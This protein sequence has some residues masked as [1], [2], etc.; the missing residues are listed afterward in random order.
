MSLYL[1]MDPFFF[2]M[3]QRQKHC[4][5]LIIDVWHAAAEAHETTDFRFE[6][7]WR[8]CFEANSSDSLRVMKCEDAKRHKCY[9]HR[10]A[11]CILQTVSNELISVQTVIHKCINLSFRPGCCRDYNLWWEMLHDT[12]SEKLQVFSQIR[13]ERI[14]RR[15]VEPVGFDS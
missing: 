14:S 9:L 6:C 8:K 3:Q 13:I 10:R 4:A 15:D 12:L 11:F 7:L 2:H 1:N 5:W